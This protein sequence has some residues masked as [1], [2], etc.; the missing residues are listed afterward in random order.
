MR[1]F[2]TGELI[3][4]WTDTGDSLRVQAAVARIP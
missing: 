4:A 3:F 1:Y 2:F